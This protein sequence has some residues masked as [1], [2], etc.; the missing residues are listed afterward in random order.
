MQ[1]CFVISPIGDKDSEIRKRSDQVLKFIISPAVK[2]YNYDAIRADQLAD[3]GQITTNIILHIK[4]DPLV[5]ADLT[6]MNP[7]VFYELAIRHAIQKPFIHI[8]KKGESIPFDVSGT[9]TIFFDLQ[10][11]Q[12]IEDAKDDIGKQ[13]EKLESLQEKIET[14][15]SFAINVQSLSQ[16][17]KPEDR[18]LAD[19]VSALS[20]IKL[21]LVNLEKQISYHG[22]IEEKFMYVENFLQKIVNDS[23]IQLSKL[24]NINE[25]LNPTSGAATSSS[26]ST[27]YQGSSSSSSTAYQGSSSSSSTGK[28]PRYKGS[29]EKPSG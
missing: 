24:N 28:P 21:S 13:I 8:I 7:N 29:T 6:G 9:K 23:Q 10:D 11:P 5:I 22:D 4:D 25:F 1:T 16:S 27:G 3:P 12:S 26:S 19:I 20:E 15:I 14:P 2:P 18:S 17:D